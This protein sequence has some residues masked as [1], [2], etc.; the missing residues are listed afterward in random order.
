MTKIAVSIPEAIEMSG[1]KRS[2]LY[3]LFKAG[4]IQPRKNGKRTLILVDDLERYLKSLPVA[5]H[6]GH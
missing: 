2:S 1:I 4:K 5:D 6:G 3:E